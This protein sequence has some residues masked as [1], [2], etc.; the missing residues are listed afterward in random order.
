MG[1][2]GRAHTHTDPPPPPSE[3][4]SDPTLT[5]AFSVCEVYLLF[6]VLYLFDVVLAEVRAAHA[7]LEALLL[8]ILL[9]HLRQQQ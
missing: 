6:E 2:R 8:R 3:Q 7:G 1:L 9:L 5:P 4:D